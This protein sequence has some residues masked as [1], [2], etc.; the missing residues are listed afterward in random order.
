MGFF[1]G[2]GY[3]YSWELAI[4][5]CA[6]TCPIS[7]VTSGKEVRISLANLNGIIPQELQLREVKLSPEGMIKVR[8]T[9][10]IKIGLRL[11]EGAVRR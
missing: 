1:N 10:G 9:I 3:R 7:Y 8:Q 2:A 5:N 4:D 6:I 11:Y